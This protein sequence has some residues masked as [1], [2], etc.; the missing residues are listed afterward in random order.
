MLRL[1]TNILILKSH[2]GIDVFTSCT[3][4]VSLRGYHRQACTR[5]RP[6]PPA[7]VL[8]GPATFTV[9]LNKAQ[10]SRGHRHGKRICKGSGKGRGSARE[11]CGYILVFQ[12]CSKP[13]DKIQWMIRSHTGTCTCKSQVLHPDFLQQI[14]GNGREV[15][16]ERET[17][18][19][20]P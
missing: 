4:P 18:T 15:E 11:K 17:E 9:K 16:R 10:K 2:P 8:P 14:L 3:N 6:G 13:R 12:G 20:C 7:Q 5:L 1:P 19:E